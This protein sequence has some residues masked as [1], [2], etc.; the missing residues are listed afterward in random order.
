MEFTANHFQTSLVT[1]TNR[2]TAYFSISVTCVILTGSTFAQ[3][4]ILEL[5]DEFENTSTIN[6]W[7]RIHAV[8]GWNA[9]QLITWDINTTRAGRMVIEPYTCVW[10]DDYR[11][12]LIFK[13]VSGDFAITV[14]IHVNDR[15]PS[16]NNDIPESSFSLAGIMIRTPRAILIPATDWQ[17]GGENYVFLSLGNGDALGSAPS[18]QFEVKTTMNSNSTLILQNTSTGTAKIQIV[19]IGSNVITLLQ[20]SG[21]DWVVHRRYDRSDLPETLQ[22]GMVAYTDWNVASTFSPFVQNSSVLTN[23]NNANPDIIAEYE[24]IRYDRPQIPS[25]LTEQD[26]GPGSNVTDAE[27]LN[28]LGEHVDSEPDTKVSN[29][30]FYD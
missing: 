15:N 24:Y 5:S 18:F 23:P 28:F 16:D 11:G 9:D 19:R 17:P 22:A 7:Q 4:S 26:L 13:E 27:L 10:F 2:I 14:E 20:E 29:W 21:Q 12:P 30:F 6:D 1:F 25:S 8:E 3:T